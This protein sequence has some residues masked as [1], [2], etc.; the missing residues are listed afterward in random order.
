MRLLLRRY[1]IT[2]RILAELARAATPAHLITRSPLIVRDLD[3][4]I[5]LARAAAFSVCVS[6]PT[7]D[8]ELSRR[9]EPT[10][11]P[12]AQRLR[13]VGERAAEAQRGVTF[14]PPRRIVPAPPR[15]LA[16]PL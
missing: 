14:A 4:V 1:R 13:A 11:A 10:V 3:V 9:I 6:L 8:A 5:G 7:L 12:P 16:L 15:E 2:H